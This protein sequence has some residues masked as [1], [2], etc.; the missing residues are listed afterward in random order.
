MQAWAV[1]DPESAHN[2]E[3]CAG[4]G[5]CDYT[6]GLCECFDGYTG[7]ACERSACPNDCSGHGTCRMIAD[8]PNYSAG[9]DHAKVGSEYAWDEKAITACVCDGGYMGPDC[10]QRICPF[11]DDPMTVCEQG[12]TEQI[13]VI[14][15]NIPTKSELGSTDYSTNTASATFGADNLA[16][17]TFAVRYTSYDNKEWTTGAFAGMT[18]SFPLAGA[19]DQTDDVPEAALA[20][21]ETALKALPNFAVKDVSATVMIDDDTTGLTS[22]LAVTFLHESSGNSFGPQNLLKCPQRRYVGADVRGDALYT[23]GCAKEG[24][25]PKIMQPRLVLAGKSTDYGSTFGAAGANVKFSTDSVL[26]CPIGADCTQATAFVGGI[27]VAIGADSNS[28]LQVWVQALDGQN[29]LA[30]MDTVAGAASVADYV[31][32]ATTNSGFKFHGRVADH[33]ATGNVHKVDISRV[34]ADT[35]LDI[36]SSA[37]ADGDLYYLQWI[38]ARC[39]DAV[40]MTVDFTVPVVNTDADALYTGAPMDNHDVENIEC[41]GRGQCDREA[42]TCQCFEGYTGLACGDQTILV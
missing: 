14:K 6:T 31:A 11:G 21:A 1:D 32:G 24:C 9:Y 35:S 17:N 30:N 15:I 18:T 26:T 40:D 19:G 25:Q 38:P 34:M 36:D 42:G 13:Q 4:K 10:S 5:L 7:R 22:S 3:E 2:Y 37:V 39:I 16:G 12:D 41:S 28:N 8:L 27:V 20:A 23:F 33:P 29:T